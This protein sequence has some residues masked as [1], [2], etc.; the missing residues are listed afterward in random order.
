MHL[1]LKNQ[2]QYRKGFLQFR[3]PYPAGFGSL[4]G[5]PHLGTDI[6]TPV[7]VPLYAMFDGVVKFSTGTQGGRTATLRS[8]N[9]FK[10]IDC[11]EFDI[12]YMH[13][14]RFEGVGRT[15]K[16]G[17]VIGYAG[18]TGASTAPHLHLDIRK[19]GSSLNI[20]NFYDPNI[21]FNLIDMKLENWQI[22]AI[23]FAKELGYSNGERP[24][25][26][27]TRVEVMEMI[28]KYHLRHQV[29]KS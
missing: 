5:Q 8:Q 12:R 19:A 26:P 17:D 2:S 10:E 6:L 29:D 11:K 24:L 16:A 21:I 14:D 13:L 18:N 7:G 27:I 25:E 3:T 22:E 20:N 15:V 28:R 1:P 23:R 9:P 4:S